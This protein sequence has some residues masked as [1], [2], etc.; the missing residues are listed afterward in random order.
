MFSKLKGSFIKVFIRKSTFFFTRH[1]TEVYSWLFKHLLFIIK[2]FHI[3]YFIR[4]NCAHLLAST[5][6]F[7][8][9]LMVLLDDFNEG[10]V[11]TLN[12]KWMNYFS[13]IISVGN[14]E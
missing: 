9:L 14:K 1:I 4:E 13:Y 10:K 2:R 11:G 7:W 3:I 12:R 8:N 5:C 6:E